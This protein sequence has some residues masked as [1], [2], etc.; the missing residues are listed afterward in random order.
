MPK[1][2][3]ITGTSSGVGLHTAA[4]LASKG[5]IVYATMRDLSKRN[6]LDEL[7]RFYSN[8]IRIH[9]LDV[10]KE[11]SIK[12]CVKTILDNEQRLDVLINNAGAGFIRSLEQATMEEIQQVMDVNFYGPIRCIKAVLPAM[13]EQNS[14]HIINISSVGGL[15]GQPVNEIY[16]AAKFALEGLTESIATYLTPYFGIKTSIIEPAGITT[17]FGNNLMNYFNNTGGVREDDYMPLFNDYMDYRKTFTDELKAKIFQSPLQVALVID[18]CISDPDPKLRYLTS[19][20]A[21]D[22]THLK[23][24]LDPDGTKLQEAIRKRILNK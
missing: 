21:A 11:D 19:A 7:T 18:K 10:Q 9:Y 14:G 15:V 17:E 3:L 12:A 2:I 5:H 20:Y 24:G 4:L 16:C 13:R 22:F 8:N 6:L 1:T 23:S